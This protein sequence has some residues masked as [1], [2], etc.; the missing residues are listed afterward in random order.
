MARE[1][2]NKKPSRLIALSAANK[3]YEFKDP[4]KKVIKYQGKKV[5]IKLR[6]TRLQQVLWRLV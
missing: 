2:K 1:P 3:T 4:L 5:D 6:T